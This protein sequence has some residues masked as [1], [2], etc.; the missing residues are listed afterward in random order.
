MTD[1]AFHPEAL[2]DLDEIWEF[3]AKDNVDAANRIVT[4]VLATC[5]NLSHLPLQGHH[6]PELSS[7]SLRFA[8]VREYLLAYAPDERP[9]WVVAILHGKRNPRILAAILRDRG[10]LPEDEAP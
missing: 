9:L 7:R 4:Q 5:E 10:S 2:N 6:R 1:Y 3:I 8:V